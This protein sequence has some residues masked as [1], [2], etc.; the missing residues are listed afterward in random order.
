MLMLLYAKSNGDNWLG[1]LN[2]HHHQSP[3][4]I[5]DLVLVLVIRGLVVLVK[6]IPTTVS[7][8]QLNLVT[9][10]TGSSAPS[11]ARR[12]FFLVSVGV[13]SRRD[14]GTRTMIVFITSTFKAVDL[15][16]GNL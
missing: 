16:D 13:P 15:S 2:L 8:V 11:L 3:D 10:G 7:K 4:L 14:R 9:I 12:L 6:L 5:L 1:L